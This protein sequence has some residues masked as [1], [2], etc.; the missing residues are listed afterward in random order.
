MI[1]NQ[2][3]RR[4]G[5]GYFNLES[6]EARQFDTAASLIFA[7]AWIESA[8]ESGQLIL[9]GSSKFETQLQRCRRRLQPLR[10]GRRVFGMSADEL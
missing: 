8:K 2:E 4:F 5:V 6:L 7:E 9:S 10:S 3:Y 1:A